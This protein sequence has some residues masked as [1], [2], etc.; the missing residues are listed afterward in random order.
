[1]RVIY[2]PN[3][4][5]K[6]ID[7]QRKERYIT[8]L[9]DFIRDVSR[10]DKNLESMAIQKYNIKKMRSTENI[11][12]FYLD[13]QLGSRCLFQYERDHPIFEDEP[14]IALLAIT[15]H[16]QQG[17]TA[18]RLDGMPIDLQQ[19]ILLEEEITDD[20]FEDVDWQAPFMKHV[21]FK[22][23]TSE[24]HF[25]KT[26]ELNDPKG[27]Y[28][29]SPN[30]RHA[31]LQEGPVF[32][33]GC[34]GSGKTLVEISKALKL[35]HQ[36][37]KQGYFTFTELLKESA[38]AL[39]ED[40]QD[41][42]GIQ[43]K[44][45]FY[46]IKDY[47]LK[48]LDLRDAQYFSF[49]RYL[50]WYDKENFDVRFPKLK[51][52]GK[53][54]LWIELRGI[55][56]GYVGNHKQRILTLSNVHDVLSEKELKE[57]VLGKILTKEK[58]SQ[59][60]YHILDTGRLMEWSKDRHVFRHYLS[61]L[62]LRQPMLDNYAYRKG[63]AEHYSNLSQEERKEA[64]KFAKDYYQKHLVSQDPPLVDDNDLAR[65]LLE[66]IHLGKHEER[67]DYVFI[68]E[69]QDLTEMQVLTL[70]F[71]AHHPERLYMTGD[72]SQT[73]NPTFFQTGRMGVIFKHHHHNIT[74]NR[75]VTLNENYRN[76]QAVVNI[77]RTLLTLRVSILGTYHDD[78]EE[79]SKQ[80]KRKKGVPFYIDAKDQ[81]IIE[82]LS[83]WIDLPNV[84]V[85]VAND[86]AKQ[87]LKTRLGIQTETNLYT[88]SEVKGYEF[89]KIFLYDILSSYHEAWEHLLNHP[90]DRKKDIVGRY[91]FY[92]NLLYVAITRARDHLFM[93][94]SHPPQTLLNQIKP[95]F[96]VIEDNI[97]DVMDLKAYQNYDDTLKQAQAFFQLKEYSRARTYFLRIERKADADK[98]LGFEHL[99]KGE[100]L[101]GVEC[102]Y[103][104]HDNYKELFEYT[105]LKTHRLLHILLG[106]KSFAIDIETL[107][108]YLKETPLHELLK[109]YVDHVLY[110][111]LIIDALKVIQAINQH[112]LQAF[113]LKEADYVRQTTSSI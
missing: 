77:V 26:I 58:G 75:S 63:M 69:M 32:L 4:L 57:L 95:L 56:K 87:R 44:T 67:F 88:V 64:L 108:R 50:H 82:I 34:A 79:Q 105:T 98:A 71:L 48:A 66:K 60:R 36:N 13:P 104:S 51:A 101:K 5:F 76:S 28:E 61:E 102:L 68:D 92:F 15:E 85:I 40:Y 106:F 17:T 91:K 16:D 22:D 52:I 47:M 93:F 43:G 24:E 53:I 70:S 94:E 96:D 90:I 83:A 21:L 81:D 8:K 18:R 72:V 41:S 30:Q 46:T 110:P 107:E 86:H 100:F 97:V 65:L 62:N 84:A 7:D 23:N 54:S 49:E 2:N 80:V 112:H 6:G 99:Q 37:I 9:Y 20:A 25:L 109:T 89:E 19:F 10:Y 42:K 103:A 45:T 29:L 38:Q 35:A 12:K 55:L 113:K 1:M 78:I 33:L 39:Y 14:G 111:N 59:S 3:T 11:F 73:I 31:M 74:L 27:I